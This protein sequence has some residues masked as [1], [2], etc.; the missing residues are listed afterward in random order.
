MAYGFAGNLEEFIA[1]AEGCSAG[2]AISQMRQRTGGHPLSAEEQD[3]WNEDGTTLARFFRRMSLPRTSTYL[4]L[5]EYDIPGHLGRCDLVMLGADT[6]R[7][8]HASV[9]ELKRWQRFSPGPTPAFVN[10][11]GSLHLHPSEQALQYRDCLQLFHQKGREYTWHAGAWMTAM[12]SHVA[13]DLNGLAPQEAP[14][15]SLQRPEPDL[16]GAIQDWFG[17]GLP[18]V[19]LGAFRDAPCV[20]DARLAEMLLARLP[21]M[22]KGLHAAMGGKPHDL[23]QRQEEIVTAILREVRSQERVL[24]LVAGSPGCGKTVVGIHALV[25][26]LV[27]NVDHANRTIRKRSVLAL[28]NNRLCTVVRGAIDDALGTRAGRALVQYAKGGGPGAGIYY[29]VQEKMTQSA[30]PDALYDLVVIDEAHRIPN[31]NGGNPSRLSQLEAL[32]RAGRAVVC[33]YDEGQVLNDDDNGDQRTFREIWQRLC[34]KA[35]VVELRLDEQHRLPRAYIEWLEAFLAG[36]PLPIPD[37]YDFQ[38][39]SNPTEVIQYLRN[40]STSSDCGLLASYTAC[41]GR[42]GNDLRVPGLGVRWL[43]QP[44]DYNTWW[45]TRTLRHRFDRCASVYGCQGFELDYAGLFW[46]RDLALRQDQGRVSF[47][48][49][50][51]HDV[52]DD[53]QLAYGRRLRKM[54][55]E[56]QA[57]DNRALRQEVV[58]RLLNRY[59]ILLSR[60]RKGTVVYCEEDSTREALRQC[61]GRQ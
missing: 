55:D 4:M 59:R 11:G 47:D 52:K 53:I 61:I 10:V 17:G 46:G 45:R 40:R 28:R 8:K 18:E 50:R 3:V 19:E 27:R 14:V 44:N 23:S 20:A 22:T 5:H 26:Q 12:D 35:P 49:C 54:A 48:L 33:L 60:A 57:S 25:H 30:N 7:V 32:L 42:N 2:R 24:I 34:P 56:A 43:M 15:W 31:D 6:S 21:G 16:L 37:E 38:V 41:N 39:A 13:R 29:Q 9:V 36:R 58:R 51:P 1:V